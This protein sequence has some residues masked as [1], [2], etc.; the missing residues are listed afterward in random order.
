[1]ANMIIDNEKDVFQLPL[2]IEK[3]GLT[4]KTLKTKDTFV[5]KDIEIQIEIPEAKLSANGGSIDDSNKPTI[6]DSAA[7]YLTTEETKYPVSF[8]G[9][10][11]VI[12]VEQTGFVD[13]TNN[14]EIP[15]D[16]AL[17]TVYI[18]EAGFS[19]GSASGGEGT[20]GEFI[21]DTQFGDPDGFGKTIPIVVKGPEVVIDVNQTGLITSE[22]KITIPAEEI[23]TKIELNVPYGEVQ[24]Q[25]TV[26]LDEN[27]KV[28]AT[29]IDKE[30]IDEDD[31]V[32]TIKSSGLIKTTKEGWID[33]DIEAGTEEKQFVLEKADLSNTASTDEEYDI[34]TNAP[35]LISESGLFINEGYIGN[36]YIP[37]S[38]L[39]PD[40]A[41][42]R[43]QTSDKSNLIY[44]SVT[45]YDNDGNL[46][47]GTMDNATVKL[48]EGEE[49]YGDENIENN[50][51]MFS[52]NGNTVNGLL[53]EAPE[54]SDYIE[55]KATANGE[56]NFAK[57]LTYKLTEGYCS[58][59]EKTETVYAELSLAKD[60]DSKYIRIYSGSY[61]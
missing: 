10:S 33:K 39:V 48:E 14:I 6:S 17:D 46:V 60:S 45:V 26:E 30:D 59:E 19:L 28:K 37:L 18:K 8:D 55:I 40:E 57:T 24:G 47:T 54:D 20:V 9:G 56:T 7:D 25:T 2:S 49:V 4:T 53:D 23:Q 12:G 42:V 5:E 13:G 41:N 44:K 15:L 61:E 58:G 21:G 22:D 38:V 3:S 35:V 51:S 36:T 27:S 52:N 50:I 34:L 43:T 1:M 32:L 31:Y 16:G 11:I 29:L